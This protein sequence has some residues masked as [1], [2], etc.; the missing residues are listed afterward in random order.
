MLAVLGFK[1][2]GFQ[3]SSVTHQTLWRQRGTREDGHIHLAD[4]TFSVATIEKKEEEEEEEEE[5][6]KKKK[7]KK[8]KQT[9]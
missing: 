9:N 2:T 1:R 5:K 6:K 3:S 7:K 4:W 8:K